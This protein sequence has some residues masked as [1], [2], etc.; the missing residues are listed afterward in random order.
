MIE[1]HPLRD[2]V[3]LNELY[4]SAG[5]EIL[6]NSMSVVASDKGEIL[7][8]CLFD[9]NDD[10][11]TIHALEPKEDVYFADGILRSAL[12]VGVENGKSVA[13]YSEKAPENLFKTLKFIKN[14]QNRELNVEKLFSS[15]QS[16]PKD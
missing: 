1:I 11:I 16:C 15:C 6:E 14:E 10:N 7:G 12:H 4:K 2:S 9:M 5:I 3:K 8:F 13:F